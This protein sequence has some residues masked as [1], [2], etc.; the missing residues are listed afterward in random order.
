MKATIL[1]ETTYGFCHNWVLL[2]TFRNGKKR[3]FYLGQDVKF[4]QRVLGMEPAYIVQ[5]IK[6]NDLR[7]K[8]TLDKL[9]RFIL[10]SLDLNAKKLRELNA[11]DLCCQ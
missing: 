3:M 8:K 4:C 10:K 7:N 6:S 9:A 11:W 2:V 1:I 5:Q